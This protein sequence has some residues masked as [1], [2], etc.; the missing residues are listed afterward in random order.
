MSG[1]QGDP[2]HLIRWAAADAANAG[3]DVTTG[4]EPGWTTFLARRDYGRYLRDTLADAERSAL[5]IARLT[6]V[7]ANVVAVRPGNARHG[8]RLMTPAG[9]IAADLVVLATGNAPARMPVEA[10]K[11]DRVVTDP[12]G[13]GALADVAGH[14]AI[15]KRR[16]SVVIVGTGLTMLDVAVTIAASDARTVIHAISRHGLLP[17]PHP[18]A[19]PASRRPLWLPVMARADSPVR[20]V[21]LMRQVRATIDARP[22]GWFDAMDALRPLVPT[23]WRRMPV[24]D[25]RL[26]LRHLSRYWEVHRHL[27]PPATASRITALR[28][29]GRLHVHRGQVTAVTPI[30][31][32]LAVVADGGAANTNI[33]LDADWL[34]N[35]TGATA[36]ISGAASP[37][38]RDLFSTGL[39]RPDPMG[40]GV[41]AA[42]DGRVL[43]RA[44]IPSDVLLTL[45]PPLRGLWYETT[46]IPEIREQ[47]AELA[48]RITRDDLLRLRRGKAA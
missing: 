18:G 21:D 3:G 15:T 27:V 44:G 46:A 39:A 34:I 17:R 16:D 22:T 9:Q 42:P 20:L 11:S 31:D 19:A 6:R 32:R 29:T 35:G 7:T 25:K 45:G 13:P 23:L 12:W 37:L 24:Q 1:I 14:D 2:D 48:Q 28:A 41:D 40:L 5:P 30:A 8:L 4:R 43:S 10:P 47:A 26:F 38:L 33:A 36:D